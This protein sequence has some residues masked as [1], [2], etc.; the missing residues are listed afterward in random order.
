MM[1]FTVL[2]QL[3]VQLSRL[4][5]MGSTFCWHFQGTRYLEEA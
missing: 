1:E 3:M 5:P 2:A 4:M